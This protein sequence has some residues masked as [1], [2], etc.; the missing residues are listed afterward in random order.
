MFYILN[1]YD[2]IYL[3]FFFEIKD[4]KISR[5]HNFTPVKKQSRLDDRKFFIF[6]ARVPSMYGIHY[7]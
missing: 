2:N 3:I 1:G 4:S 6:L 7:H 5:G